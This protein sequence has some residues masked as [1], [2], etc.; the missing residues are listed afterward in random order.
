[1][2]RDLVAALT[3][4]WLLFPWSYGSWWLIDHPAHALSIAIS[5]AIAGLFVKIESYN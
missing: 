3:I 4:P 5:F 2:N 1:M